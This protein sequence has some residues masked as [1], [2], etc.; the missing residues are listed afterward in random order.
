MKTGSYWYIWCKCI[1]IWNC[2][3]Y[4]NNAKS[5]QRNARAVWRTNRRTDRRK[6]IPMCLFTRAKKCTATDVSDQAIKVFIVETRGS[7]DVAVVMK[8]LQNVAISTDYSTRGPCMPLAVAIICESCVAVWNKWLEI[9]CL[10]TRPGNKHPYKQRNSC[11]II[12]V[13]TNATSDEDQDHLVLRPHHVFP[14][15][16]PH[17]CSVP[18]LNKETTPLSRPILSR[19]KTGL[20]TITSYYRGF[21]A[22][23]WNNNNSNMNTH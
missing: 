19:L 4:C 17:F 9:T 23:I 12:L 13:I 18:E 11:I 3:H 5:D 20:I 6:V 16:F 1:C 14:D 15:E 22:F 21:S 10:Q 7:T 8:A 2:V